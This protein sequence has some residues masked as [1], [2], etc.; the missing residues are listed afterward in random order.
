MKHSGYSSKVLPAAASLL[1]LAAVGC[2]RNQV[3]VYE[4]DNVESAAPATVTAPNMAMPPNMTGDIP[5]MDKSTLPSLKFVKPDSWKEKAPTQMRVAS[6]EISE[7][8]E[9][10]DVSV[11][12]LSGTAG[13]DAANVN[14]WR[15]QVGLQP[16]A[17]EELLKQAEKVEIAGQPADLYDVA[18]VD[19]GTGDA[20]RIIGVIFHRDGTAWFIK[21]IG[22]S[23][24]AAKNKTGFI[25]FLK[26]IE[27][28]GA[29][30]PSA[31]DLNQL[32]ASH[33]PIN[34]S[35]PGT[36]TAA[37]E[38]GNKPAW[39]VPAGWQ[40]GPLAQF[41]IAKFIITGAG[42][43]KAEVNVSSLTGD[44]GGLLPNINRWRGQLGLAPATE[45]SAT[46][47]DTANG[48]AS[49]VEFSGTNGRTGKAAQLVGIIVPV[50][51]ET[52]FYKLMGDSEVV[53]AQKTA[54]T[55]FVQSAKYSH[56]H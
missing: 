1:L 3:K 48:K 52:W 17:E 21:M 33:P 35:S 13:G 46:S 8:N 22:A 55:Q 53:N 40:E 15:G 42:D 38:V 37:S 19:Q 25:A 20:Q 30:A 29:A 12:P 50:G 47:I 16:L 14:R 11:I 43:S 18:A 23:N 41:L 6:F 2:D 45:V 44:G 49:V 9:K 51:D 27:F 7:N 24:L 28:G 31:M 26:S 36:T 54:L 39:T 5:M 32:P 34:S 56:A 10:V 4:V